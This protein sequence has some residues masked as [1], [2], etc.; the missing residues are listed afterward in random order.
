MRPLGYLKLQRQNVEPWSWG[1]GEGGNGEP[2]HNGQ[3]DSVWKDEKVL[4]MEGD[5][6]YNT[7]NVFKATEVHT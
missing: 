5:G 7:P 1:Q 6:W 4:E 2:V 3:G